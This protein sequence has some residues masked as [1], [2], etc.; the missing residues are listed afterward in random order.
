MKEGGIDKSRKPRL[1]KPAN[2]LTT[3]MAVGQLLGAMQ[4]AQAAEALA[5]NPKFIAFDAQGAVAEFKVLDS[6]IERDREIG[7]EIRKMEKAY[8]DPALD[9]EKFFEEVLR[10]GR[11][12]ADRFWFDQSTT[13]VDL[14]TGKM[15]PK[16]SERVHIQEARG[17]SDTL[18]NGVRVP[19]TDIVFGDKLVNV[20]VSHM[21]MPGTPGYVSV[22]ADIAASVKGAVRGGG[23]LEFSPLDPLFK[24]GVGLAKGKKQPVGVLFDPRKAQELRILSMRVKTEDLDPAFRHVAF[25]SILNSPGIYCKVLPSGIHADADPLQQTA[26]SSGRIEVV[27][28]NGRPVPVGVQMIQQTIPDPDG[29]E[30]YELLCFAGQ[31]Q[32]QSAMEKATEGGGKTPPF[33]KASP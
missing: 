8:A 15:F 10:R 14:A 25:D 9:K 22:G 6:R 27:I 17:L 24:L 20:T 21:V 23:Y 13:H 16:P 32:L 3:T 4:P 30:A 28:E 29:G 18:P 33:V 31:R 12:I 11:D 1:A 19:N 5:P 2:L 7:K 26:G